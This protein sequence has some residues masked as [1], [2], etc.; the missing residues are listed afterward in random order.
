MPD[1]VL[2]S[3]MLGTGVV[4]AGLSVLGLP[5]WNVGLVSGVF[6]GG[7]GGLT[8]TGVA[9]APGHLPQVICITESGLRC[10]W[11]TYYIP[12]KRS[13]GNIQRENLVLHP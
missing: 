2:V 3:G 9:E 6:D 13:P 12:C 7:D 8:G 11:V 5:G 10:G 1:G 4:R